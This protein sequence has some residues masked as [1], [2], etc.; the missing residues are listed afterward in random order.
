MEQQL[1]LRTN[2]SCLCRFVRRC[3]LGSQPL[4]VQAPKSSPNFMA[5]RS[6]PI[7]LTSAPLPP[8]LLHRAGPTLESHLCS[9]FETPRA[10]NL[11]FNCSYD[12]EPAQS[13]V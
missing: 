7:T 10:M 9:Q 8:A 1:R 2:R 6:A 13:H 12:L 4:R 11:I 5:A 3:S